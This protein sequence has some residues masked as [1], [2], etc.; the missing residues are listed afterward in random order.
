MPTEIALL[1]LFGMICVAVAAAFALERPYN[2]V[3]ES[4]RQTTS[5]L[6]RRPSLFFAALAIFALRAVLSFG[7]MRAPVNVLSKFAINIILQAC[8]IIA[9]AH[10]A[11]RLH[12]G[13]IRNEWLSVFTSGRR[14]WRMAFYVLCCWALLGVV[15]GLPLPAPPMVSK[16]MA[17]LMGVSLSMI[18]VFLKSA[19]LLGGPAASLDEPHPLRRALDS[20]RR[21]PVSMFALILITGFLGDTIGETMNALRFFTHGSQVVFF[22]SRPLVLFAQTFLF[23]LSEFALV[24]LLT[25]I[26]EDRY[27]LETRNAAHNFNWL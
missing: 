15:G 2:I 17:G 4:W 7:L 22:L 11:L 18:V 5:L 12:R 13:L 3:A 1:S 21:A 23:A 20:F 8:I 6:L 27:E 14:E 26:C 16:D 19:L 9:L 10:V 24:I 25:R